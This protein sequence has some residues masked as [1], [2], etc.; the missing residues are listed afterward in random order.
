MIIIIT[1]WYAPMQDYEFEGKKV[2][3]GI[4]D[5]TGLILFQKK[6]FQNCL[7]HIVWPAL[8]SPPRRSCLRSFSIL[9]KPYCD[10]GCRKQTIHFYLNNRIFVYI[11]EASS[12][13]FYLWAECV[14]IHN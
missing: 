10:T 2:F 11:S 4:E 9:T 3:Q 6:F 13:A 7:K 12:L 1:H 14:L 8:R 5:E